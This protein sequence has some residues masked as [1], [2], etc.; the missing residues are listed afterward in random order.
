MSHIPIEFI[1][2]KAQRDFI[3]KNIDA[4]ITSVVNHGNF[5]MGPEVQQFENALADC[6][7]AKFALGCGNGTDALQL[8]LMAEDIGTNDAVFVPAFTFVATAECIPLLGAT[9]VFVD[10]LPDTFN[11]D[12]N[13]LEDAIVMSKKQG[14]NPKAI[15]PADLFGQ[16]A[17][18]RSINSLAKKYNLIVVADAAQGLG[19]TL[20]GNRNRVDRLRLLGN[21]VVPQTAAKA[22]SVL[23]ERML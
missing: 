4:A 8:V 11:M 20:D 23:S 5:I 9:P 17:D 1:D 14:L 2:L 16:P 7:G 15:I 6:C 12:P 21:A 22:Y 18:Y 19:G 3:R 10:V 13:S